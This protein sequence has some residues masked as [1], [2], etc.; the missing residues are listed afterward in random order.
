MRRP[1]S[2][3]LSCEKMH[4]I[5]LEFLVKEKEFPLALVRGVEIRCY[6][7]VRLSGILM[8]LRIRYFPTIWCVQLCLVL[9]SMYRVLVALTGCLFLLSVLAT[10]GTRRPCSCCVRSFVKSDAQPTDTFTITLNCA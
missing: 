5:A 6:A 2:A 10:R 1:R 7:V 3:N 4:C 8:L 9:M